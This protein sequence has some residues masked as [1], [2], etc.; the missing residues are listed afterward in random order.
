MY[1]S[2]VSKGWRNEGDS[3]LLLIHTKYGLVQASQNSLVA[4]LGR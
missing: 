4:N 1:L 2:S 3:L